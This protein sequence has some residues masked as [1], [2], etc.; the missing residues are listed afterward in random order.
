[1]RKKLAA[2]GAGYGLAW[3]LVALLV[4]KLCLNAGFRELT[5]IAPQYLLG[6][7]LTGILMTLALHR[8]LSLARPW[9]VIPWGLLALLGGTLAFAACMLVVNVCYEFITSLVNFGPEFA[10]RTLTHLHDSLI[11]F[12]W[13]PLY[14]FGTVVPIFLAVLNCWDLRRRMLLASAPP[15]PQP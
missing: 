6:A 12:F 14:G 3:G 1:M 9:A 2:I 4:M 11:M 8:P 5:G 10:F 15:C 13:Y 7:V